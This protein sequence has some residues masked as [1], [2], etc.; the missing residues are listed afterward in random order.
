MYTT[1]ALVSTYALLTFTAT[2][3]AAYRFGNMRILAVAP[4]AYFLVHVGYAIGFI[5]G[6]FSR[7][8]VSLVQ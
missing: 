8:V 1:I 4:V 2:F 5:L 6:S 7:D 3:L